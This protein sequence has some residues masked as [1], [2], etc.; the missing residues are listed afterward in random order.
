MK[1]LLPIFI[2]VFIISCSKNKGKKF[3]DPEYIPKL[4]FSYIDTNGNDLLNSENPNAFQF[5]TMRLFYVDNGMKEEARSMDLDCD[6]LP[7]CILGIYL[8][9]STI[10]T[11][12]TNISDTITL[13]DNVR[14]IRYNGE[15]IWDASIDSLT[16]PIATIIK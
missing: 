12:G 8:K 14:I 1:K 3:Y 11:I 13:H 15:I 16:V 9:D 10:L 6:N 5:N 2:F 4:G 7:V